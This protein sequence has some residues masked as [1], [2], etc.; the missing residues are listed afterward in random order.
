[1][2]QKVQIFLFSFPLL[3]ALDDVLAVRALSIRLIS[4]RGDEKIYRSREDV[5]EKEWGK[6]QTSANLFH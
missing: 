4:T 1:M 3:I 2:L 5:N 6:R